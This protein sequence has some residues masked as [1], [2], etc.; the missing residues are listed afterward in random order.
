MEN[1]IQQEINRA[2]QNIGNYENAIRKYVDELDQHRHTLNGIKKKYVNGLKKNAI[3]VSADNNILQKLKKAVEK[4]IKEFTQSRECVIINEVGEG[5]DITPFLKTIADQKREI[6]RLEISIASHLSDIKKLKDDIQIIDVRITEKNEEISKLKTEILKKDTNAH[7]NNDAITKLESEK[8]ELV[9]KVNAY[10]TELVKLIDEVSNNCM[11]SIVI[12]DKLFSSSNEE[13]KKGLIQEKEIMETIK[14]SLDYEKIKVESLKKDLSTKGTITSPGLPTIIP[15]LKTLQNLK[16]INLNSLDTLLQNSDVEEWGDF[17]FNYVFSTIIEMDNYAI[18][19]LNAEQLKI[20]LKSNIQKIYLFQKLINNV[21]RLDTSKID[22]ALVILIKKELDKLVMPTITTTIRVAS[23]SPPPP[24]IPPPPPLPLKI[25]VKTKSETKKIEKTIEKPKEIKVLELISAAYVKNN[26]DLN[27]NPLTIKDK[28]GKPVKDE[29]GQDLTSKDETNDIR[30]IAKLL[31]QFRKFKGKGNPETCIQITN[32][33]FYKI[34]GFLV[35]G[36]PTD[37]EKTYINQIDFTGVDETECKNI[38]DKLSKKQILQS[39]DSDSF[40]R[41]QVYNSTLLEYVI[42]N[43]AP[44]DIKMLSLIN[45]AVLKTGDKEKKADI[46]DLCAL[47][48][49]KIN[50]L[51]S[52]DATTIWPTYDKA[53]SEKILDT[54]M[55]P[56]EIKTAVDDEKNIF[57]ELAKNKDYVKSI[58]SDKVSLFLSS[59]AEV[60]DED[61]PIAAI[62]NITPDLFKIL[63]R[64]DKIYEYLFNA[65][66]YIFMP[67]INIEYNKIITDTVLSLPKKHNIFLKLQHLNGDLFKYNLGQGE[68]AKNTLINNNVKIGRD[69]IAAVSISRID[70]S[71]YENLKKIINGAEYNDKK[72]RDIIQKIYN[73]DNVGYTKSWEEYVTKYK[74]ITDEKDLTL[75]DGK[76]LEDKRHAH[77]LIFLTYMHVLENFEQM[78]NTM[79]KIFDDDA[80]NYADTVMELLIILFFNKLDKWNDTDEKKF[81]ALD[82]IRGIFAILTKDLSVL[83]TF[84]Y[85]LCFYNK[86]FISNSL[87]SDKLRDRP[88]YDD[89]L[90]QFLQIAYNNRE[91][92]NDLTWFDYLGVFHSMKSD[93]LKKLIDNTIIKYIHAELSKSNKY[94]KISFDIALA[95]FNLNKKQYDADEKNFFEKSMERRNKPITDD[96]KVVNDINIAADEKAA[97]ADKTAADEKAAAVD[98]NTK[99]RKQFANVGSEL[100][101]IKL[102][103]HRWYKPS[104]PIETKLPKN[105]LFNE[106]DLFCNHIKGVGMEMYLDSM[107]IFV[108]FS[109][110]KNAQF[111]QSVKTAYEINKNL[112]FI[113]VKNIDRV[114]FTNIYDPEKT[115]LD[116]IYNENPPENKVIPDFHNF[117]SIFSKNPDLYKKKVIPYDK[118]LNMWILPHKIYTSKGKVYVIKYEVFC[119][120]AKC[121]YYY[122]NAVDKKYILIGL[123]TSNLYF[124]LLSNEQLGK[125]NTLKKSYLKLGIVDAEYEN[126]ISQQIINNKLHDYIINV[127][128]KLISNERTFHFNTGILTMPNGL[129]DLERWISKYLMYIPDAYIKRNI[130]MQICQTVLFMLIQL[131]NAGLMYLDLKIENIMFFLNK[132]GKVSIKFI[133]LGSVFNSTFRSA[134]Y[135]DVYIQCSKAN[136]AFTFDNPRL[137]NFH[138]INKGVEDGNVYKTSIYNKNVES[139]Q[140]KTADPKIEKDIDQYILTSY[141]MNIMYF[142]LNFICFATTGRNHE[143]DANGEKEEDK[144]PSIQEMERYFKNINMYS[145]TDKKLVSDKVINDLANTFITDAKD[146]E[147]PIGEYHKNITKQFDKFIEYFETYDP[148]EDNATYI[149]NQYSTVEKFKNKL[150]LAIKNGFT[151][152]DVDINLMF[153]LN[154]KDGK[155]LIGDW[156]SEDYIKKFEATE[157]Y[158]KMAHIADISYIAQTIDK[159]L[160]GDI[161]DEKLSEIPVFPKKIPK[162]AITVLENIDIS[163]KKLKDMISNEKTQRNAR[164]QGALNHNGTYIYIGPMTIKDV[165]YDF[166]KDGKWNDGDFKVV[167]DYKKILQMINVSMQKNFSFSSSD[168]NFDK[169]INQEKSIF[170]FGPNINKDIIAEIIK[171]IIGG[172]MYKEIIKRKYLIR[173]FPE[174]SSLNRKEIMTE[175]ITKLND[176]AAVAKTGGETPRNLILTGA[177]GG[178]ITAGL[179]LGSIC[180]G[181]LIIL[182]ALCIYILYCVCDDDKPCKKN[183]YDIYKDIYIRG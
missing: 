42:E 105:V 52:A 178:A 21:E 135:K 6:N 110:K 38:L 8:N 121:V 30:L 128:S 40:Y 143:G 63:I 55:T 174:D 22:D 156:A 119:G 100:K 73:V 168:V 173:F 162:A 46:Q 34:L 92:Y 17:E 155:L 45:I 1:F 145:E 85:A 138:D 67:N 91:Y 18:Y 170:I 39:L 41:M 84:P 160:I 86:N 16:L 62:S 133:D 3:D 36:D 175:V 152:N 171:D 11:Q 24:K 108:H 13:E 107:N 103:S 54:K 148:A 158:K 125:Q 136:T 28:N 89:Y 154:E 88:S 69:D 87:K 96:E 61:F 118:G 127:D 126:Y 142:V 111:I 15:D 72:F 80:K 120:G 70:N 90:T 167:D 124:K 147:T 165:Q 132:E 172:D 93:N 75:T 97:A 122:Y 95:L 98:E 66:Y 74:N 114:G 113:S 146:T 181:A 79:R 48:R 157:S 163:Q 129:I 81:I 177:I 64:E 139:G 59:L 44:N 150:S 71:H 58:D 78:N 101:A 32:N 164:N 117:E 153:N 33:S 5:E 65:G 141:K 151:T 49:E 134:Y 144:R 123:M 50:K 116:S 56:K 2:E 182:I 51:R 4:N 20:L 112:E 102:S 166:D 26:F 25:P 137:I 53:C 109:N 82:A 140:L 47:I 180:V 94:I 176:N 169:Y 77:V 23:T 161:I 43:Y 106:K 68:S 10:L 14:K 115:P 76:I 60:K 12:N 31:S 183:K 57:I 19:K 35:N 149:L 37:D 9:N 99:F 29:T 131:Y 159:K 83:Q 7:E 104:E 179:C 130:I 27:E